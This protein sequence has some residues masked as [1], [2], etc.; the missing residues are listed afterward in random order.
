MYCSTCGVAVTQGLSYCNYCGATLSRA[1]G[2]TRIKSPE[3]SVELLEIRHGSGL[4]WPSC[5]CWYYVDGRREDLCSDL[6]SA[7]RYSRLHDAELS[8]NASIECIRLVIGR[9]RGAEKQRYSCL[10]AGATKELTQ[11][12]AASARTSPARRDRAHPRALSRNPV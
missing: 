1:K 4:S 6:N 10:I 7:E 8:D 9:K 11:T 12:G 3:K 2:E 5:G